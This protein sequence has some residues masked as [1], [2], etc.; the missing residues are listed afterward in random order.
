MPLDY[1]KF[2]KIEDS[3]DEAVPTEQPAQ[4]PAGT[5]HPSPSPAR[6]PEEHSKP[7]TDAPALEVGDGAWVQYYTEKMSAPQRMQTMVHLWNSAEQEQRVEFLRHLIDI[8]GNPAVSNRIKGGQEILKDLD[9]NF[10]HGVTYPAAWVETFKTTLAV[11]D[12][13]AVF[14]KLFKS[15]DQAEQGLVMGTL[16]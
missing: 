10:Y 7:L 6:L 11:E 4:K 14:E 9:P 8:I 2:D 16:M 12:K 3:D 15:L 1:S 5:G 13:K